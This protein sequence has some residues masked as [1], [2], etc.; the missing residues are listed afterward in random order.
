M[1]ERDR[2]ALLELVNKYRTSTIL[3]ALATLKDPTF[4]VDV[5]D[6]GN[7]TRVY[8]VT[9]EVSEAKTLTLVSMAL[10]MGGK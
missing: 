7:F 10:G 1:D 9:S 3:G 8:Q 6:Y 5:I 2:Q 4:S